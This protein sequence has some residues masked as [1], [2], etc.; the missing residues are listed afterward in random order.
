M[1]APNF[2]KS[3]FLILDGFIFYKTKGFICSIWFIMNA[4]ICIVLGY[5]FGIKKE[6]RQ[7]QPLGPQYSHFYLLFS[8]LQAPALLI[9]YFWIP[10]SQSIT[11]FCSS[12]PHLETQS[13]FVIPLFIHLLVFFSFV[14]LKL[15][16][17]S[18]QP[19]PFFFGDN[20]KI[21]PLFSHYSH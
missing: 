1:R 15:I 6:K 13:T 10:V 14:C 19:C 5:L 12:S 18:C 11:S 21:H 3:Q 7:V 16:V 4:S 9:G 8:L 20:F 17:K 2:Y